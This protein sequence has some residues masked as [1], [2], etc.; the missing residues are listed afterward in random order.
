MSLLKKQVAS[1][2]TVP[3]RLLIYAHPGTGK[4][5]VMEGLPNAIIF[6]FESRSNHVSGSIYNIAEIAIAQGCSMYAAF[7]MAIAD[8]K[9]MVKGGQKP[10]F[11]VLDTYTSFEPIITEYATAMYNNSL[12]GKNEKLSNVV[13]QAPKGSGYRWLHDANQKLMD[14][15]RGL[16]NKAI[17]INLHIKQSSIVKHEE[18]LAADDINA[19]GK[20][21]DWLIQNAQA[22]AKLEKETE[23]GVTKAYLSFVESDRKLVCKAPP[24]IWN[25]RVLI[26]EMDGEGKFTYHWNTIFNPK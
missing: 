12:M 6:D 8:L 1:K 11:I 3:D 9:E 16:Y 7:G 22:V 17:I 2:F 20:L 10:D 14:N 19:T 4:T 5:K 15:L 18:E 26:S 23:D 13:L 24:Y 25:Q 21:R